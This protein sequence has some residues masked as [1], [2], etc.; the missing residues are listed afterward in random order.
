MKKISMKKIFLK[1]ISFCRTVCK[2]GLNEDE[3]NVIWSYSFQIK[4]SFLI[5]NGH[6]Q[7]QNI[8]QRVRFPLAYIFWG[9]RITI[10]IPVSKNN[11][12]RFLWFYPLT[13]Q[14]FQYTGEWAAKGGKEGIL[15]AYTNTSREALYLYL[16]TTPEQIYKKFVHLG[17]KHIT[18][19]LARRKL[20]I[21][22]KGCIYSEKAKDLSAEKFELVI[23]PNNIMPLDIQLAE[24]RKACAKVE[25]KLPVEKL[26]EKESEINNPI[27]IRGKINGVMLTFNL[28]KKKKR[29]KETKM[30]YVPSSGFYYKDFALFVR[31]NIHGNFTLVIRKREEIEKDKW[32]LFLESPVCSFILYHAG[33]INRYFHKKNVNLYFEKNAAKAD[34]GTWEIFQKCVCSE[35]SRNYFI[36]DGYSQAW[37]ILSE[38]KNVIRKYSAK[39]YWLLYSSDFFISTETSSHLNVHRA[40]NHYIRK[41]LLERPLIFLQHGVTY[42]KRQGNTSVFGKGKEGEPEY[43]VVGSEK[44]KKVVCEML[45]I[46]EE[47]CVKTGLPVFSTIAYEHI[48]E[49]S[50]DIVTIMLT[51][52]PSEEHLTEQFEFSDYFR[53]VV[54]INDIVS[55]YITKNKIRIVPHPKVLPL[56]LHTGLAERIWKNSVAAALED[57]KLLITDYSSVCYNAF[58]QGAGILFFQPDKNDYEKEVGKLIPKD[59][60]YIGNLTYNFETFE[61]RV[62][63]GVVN[64][65]IN[66]NYFRSPEFIKRYLQ[67]NEFHDGKNV[68]RIVR[69][70]KEKKIV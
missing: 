2:R 14:E 55:E 26:T 67:I 35:N 51:W 52:R 63:E 19:H 4:E 48:N 36:L 64:G 44:E 56:M 38:N 17:L 68:D 45:K 12:N 11:F 20:I 40:L 39:Y 15:C 5:V 8:I 13:E 59:D 28:G 49:R 57:T 33:K 24:N 29:V 58:Y 34:E 1:L 60:E 3:N 62:R 31:Q 25:I 43:M 66:L 21:D 42:L 46:K 16:F 47:Q 50:D 6:D 54:R 10:Y 53:K 27:H 32:F 18:V 9:G 37:D 23:D 69:F 65:R 61:E 41:A 7:N 22:L 70:L 30:Y